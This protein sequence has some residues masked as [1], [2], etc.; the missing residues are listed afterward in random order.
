[1]RVD[2]AVGAFERLGIAWLLVLTG[3][4][5]WIILL[6]LLSRRGGETLSVQVPMSDG[7][8]DELR[9]ERRRR[10][11]VGIGGGAAIVLALVAPTL[12]TEMQLQPVLL[13]GAAVLLVAFVV[14][15]WTADRKT[16]GVALDAS[17]RWVTLSRVHPA[18]V[19]AAEVQRAA[20]SNL[21]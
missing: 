8:Y 3:P 10:N 16:V 4:L 11:R 5:G 17:R 7:A 20:S 9:A 13:V 21:V 1:L 15:G 19:T 12:S 6:F 18:F 2:Q 14:L